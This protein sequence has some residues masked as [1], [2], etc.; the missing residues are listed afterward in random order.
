MRRSAIKSSSQSCVKKENLSPK[1]FINTQLVRVGHFLKKD[2][3]KENAYISTKSE[4]KK[5]MNII[6]SDFKLEYDM[7]NDSFVTK[8]GNK[9]NNG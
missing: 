7:R 9:A 3:N 5:R 8:Y 1:L 6:L 4:H 2:I